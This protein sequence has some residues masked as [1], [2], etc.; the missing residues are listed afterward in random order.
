MLHASLKKLD[1]DLDFSAII[2][3]LLAETGPAMTHV[4][5]L[6]R[7]IALM[8]QYIKELEEKLQADS[9]RQSPAQTSGGSGCSAAAATVRADFLHQRPAQKSGNSGP[10]AAAAKSQADFP[11]LCFRKYGCIQGM[12][13]VPGTIAMHVSISGHWNGISDFPE[14]IPGDPGPP[15]RLHAKTRSAASRTAA[16]KRR[17][18]AGISVR[19]SKTH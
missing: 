13:E 4:P 9:L 7:Q 11:A 3:P 18:G 16:L 14:T 10:S 2:N 17:T 15:R 5:K 19:T 8:K 1:R 6:A 12:A